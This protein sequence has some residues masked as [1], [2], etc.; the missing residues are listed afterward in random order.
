MA[1][2][3]KM[4]YQTGLLETTVAELKRRLDAGEAVAILDVRE[5]HEL[6]ICKL[7]YTFHIPLGQ[8]P[9]RVAELDSHKEKDFVVYCRSGKRSERACQFLRE[10][11]FA[12][13]SNLKGG[14][15]AWAGEVDPSMAKY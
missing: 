9:V 5:P 14:I 12:K 1:G 11:G 8:L 4:E 2:V 7:D 3:Y 13:V 15:L 6:E 10:N